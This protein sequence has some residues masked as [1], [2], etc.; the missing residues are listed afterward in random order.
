MERY[1]LESHEWVLV[2]ES[3]VATVGVSTHAQD[4]LG[5]VQFVELPKVGS[6]VSFKAEFSVLESMKA[7]S[8]LFSPIDGEVIEVNKNLLDSPELINESP[9]KDGWIVKVNLTEVLKKDQLMSEVD[10]FK[11]LTD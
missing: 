3:G 7:A 6:K 5:E 9:L 2:N 10:Y 8:S 4:S 11:F 1:Y